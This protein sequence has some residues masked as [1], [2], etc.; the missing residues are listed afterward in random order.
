MRTPTLSYEAAE[1]QLGPTLYE[2]AQRLLGR[3]DVMEPGRDGARLEASVM[4]SDAIHEVRLRLDGE[5]MHSWDCTCRSRELCEHAAALALAWSEIPEAFNLRPIAPLEADEQAD[6]AALEELRGLASEW[7]VS[8]YLRMPLSLANQRLRMW[9]LPWE[10]TSVEAFVV[11]GHPKAGRLLK[12]LKKLGQGRQKVRDYALKAEKWRSQAPEEPGLRSLWERLRA[13]PMPTPIWE[14]DIDRQTRL[15]GT[16]DDPP[17]SLRIKDRGHVPLTGPLPEDVDPGAVCLV[18]DVLTAPHRKSSKLRGDLVDLLSQPEWERAILDLD[19]ALE[20][21]GEQQPDG[22]GRLPGWQLDVGTLLVELVLCAPYKSK[23]GLRSWR[24]PRH[25]EVS[26]P[27]DKRVQWVAQRY[28][29]SRDERL[30]SF[31]GTLQELVGHPRVL[32]FEGVH[33]SVV[34]SELSLRCVPDGPGMRLEV[35]IGGNTLSRRELGTLR[36]QSLQGQAF[37][38]VADQVHLCRMKPRLE[39]LI[40][41]LERRGGQFPKEAVPELLARLDP[42]SLAVP[43]QLDQSLKG[44]EV[45]A[46][47]RPLLRL[48]PLARGGLELE[49]LI[50]PVVEGRAWP[51][52]KGPARPSGMRDG[53]RVHALRDLEDEERWMARVFAM[54]GLDGMGFLEHEHA[55]HQVFLHDPQ[56]ALALLERIEQHAGELQLEWARPRP[57]LSAPATAGDL[58]VRGTAQRDWFGLEGRLVVGDDELPLT[59]LLAAVRGGQRFVALDDGGWMSLSESLVQQL[60]APAQMAREG[61][62]GVE[63]PA[64]AAGLLGPLEQAGAE[65]ELAESLRDRMGQLHEAQALEPTLPAGLNATLRPYQLDGFRWLARMAHWA[66]GAVLGDDMG[67]GKTLQALALLLRRK[68][69]GPAL[70][71]APASVGLNWV[72]EARRFTPGL[73]LRVYRGKEREQALVDLG[74]GSVLVTSWELMTRDIEVLSCLPFGTVVLDEAQAIK[75]PGTR[76]AKASTRLDTQFLLALTGT[77]VENRVGELWSLFRTVAPGLLGSAEHFKVR[78]VAPIERDQEKQPREALAKVVGPFILRRLK[79]QVALDLPPRFE[80]QLTVEL[81]APERALYE[82]FRRATIAE[83]KGQVD[84]HE[85]ISSQRRVRILAAMTRLRQ[86]ACH[87]GLV[88]TERASQPSTK[89][90]RLTRMLLDL[91]DE[92]HKA[93]VFSQFTSLLKLVREHLEAQGLAIRYLDGSTPVDKRQQEVDAFQAG[94]GDAFLISL[95]AGGTGLNLTAASYVFHLDPWWNPAVEDQATDRAHRIGQDQPVT[96]YRMVAADTIEEQV[97][98][99]HRQKRELVSELLAGAGGGK[100]LSVEELLGVLEGV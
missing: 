28:G 10:P 52:G 64:L 19:A 32:D 34:R 39:R 86:L 90:K 59:E 72:R 16:L 68:D 74:P 80:E 25:R 14:L 35:A 48:S 42:L 13:V 46:D 4:G 23:A 87:P 36:E 88:E 26:D 41:V 47:P 56:R 22:R 65:L 75:N 5:L 17:P 89:L 38:R 98:A 8:E 62:E 15:Y 1:M 55:P 58:K 91:R 82:R 81:S 93:L 77:P 73:E 45:D 67:L 43:L 54:L 11:S 70:V 50:R 44:E 99:L 51:P 78:V 100:V 76:R 40:S 20:E 31:L 30:G 95:K 60:Q 6:P 21:H 53:K 27:H 83:L 63:L 3:G 2:A 57:K 96:V 85:A 7:L 92:G 71:V 24:W 69:I 94:A 49:G 33:L 18:L 66:P 12:E 37:Y 61:E 9:G 84:Q 29:Y 97:L 79:S